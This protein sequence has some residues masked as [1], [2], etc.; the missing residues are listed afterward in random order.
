M[1]VE[2]TLEIIDYS[3]FRYANRHTRYIQDNLANV[4]GLTRRIGT[5]VECDASIKAI[6]MN[7]NGQNRNKYVIQELDDEHVL[8]SND[9]LAELKARLEEVNHC[10]V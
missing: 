1:Q 10:D 4:G 6:I 2:R 7:L 3:L 9:A 5:L 8:V